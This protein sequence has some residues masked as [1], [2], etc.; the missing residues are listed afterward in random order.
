M[1]LNK[2]LFYKIFITT[3]P[4]LDQGILF[5]L[6]RPVD[7]VIK[8]WLNADWITVQ[9][10][11]SSALLLLAKHP[12]SLF[13][14]HTHIHKHKIPFLPSIFFFFLFASPLYFR[15]PFF[16]HEI[17]IPLHFRDNILWFFINESI[18]ILLEKLCNYRL[19]TN[20]ST[21]TMSFIKLR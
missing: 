9:K 14:S 11:R 12:L 3:Y 5:G 6:T 10:Y 18:I 8:R 21:S 1:S 19:M 15:F 7:K 17:R 20:A 2:A 4:C 13:L 16:F